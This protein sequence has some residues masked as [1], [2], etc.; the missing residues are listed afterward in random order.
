MRLGWS[1]IL[2]LLFASTCFA[3][4]AIDEQDIFENYLP[5]DII[6]IPVE[7]YQLDREQKKLYDLLMPENYRNE[8]P[9]R[10]EK[11]F[12]VHFKDS[13]KFFP[14]PYL[15][16]INNLPPALPHQIRG[17]ITY[18]VIFP[19]PYIYDVYWDKDEI[20]FEVR[21]HFK[22]ADSTD[23][24]ELN[25]KF[26]AAEAVW[27]NSREAFGAIKYK[28]KFK[29]ANTA[30]EA[31]FSVRLVDDTRGPYDTQWARNWSHKIIAHELGHM[32]GL[33]DEYQTV[34]GK[35]DC[36]MKSLMC[37]SF[38]GQPLPYYYYHVLRRL[39]VHLKK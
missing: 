1:L 27:N 14:D 6:E 21:V 8:D 9:A 33:G 10:A 15:L 37:S 4:D 18:V 20:V 13:L 36:V 24:E 25:K 22:D 38:Q 31:H 17:K 32:L 29:V 30:K 3:S 34:S 26:I 19:K 16:N 7:T 23:L 35:Q 12:S 11:S 2:S 5:D 39:F 28:F